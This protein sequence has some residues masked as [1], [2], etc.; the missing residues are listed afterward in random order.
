[1]PSTFGQPPL[2]SGCH[3]GCHLKTLLA[4]LCNVQ[5]A[6]NLDDLP[7]DT[8]SW[9]R[10]ET[11]Q[12]GSQSSPR[13]RK[14]VAFNL[15]PNISKATNPIRDDPSSSMRCGWI[16]HR[17]K[18]TTGIR[19]IQYQPDFKAWMHIHRQVPSG[20]QRFRVILFRMPKISGDSIEDAED[21][22]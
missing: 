6:V 16:C 22:G 11:N 4:G 18:L 10:L 21:F 19:Q 1:M 3:C 15:K 17:T 12:T 8:T 20:S 5:I 2:P 13:G 9:S 7:V 14:Q